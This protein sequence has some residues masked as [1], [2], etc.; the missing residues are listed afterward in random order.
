M[1]DVEAVLAK[2]LPYTMRGI[3]AQRGDACLGICGVHHA[4][5]FEAF[6][7]ITDDMRAYPGAI[8]RAAVRFRSLLNSYERPIFAVANSREMNAPAF[9]RRIGFKHVEG[10]VYQWPTP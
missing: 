10:Q 6:S 4:P 9:L 8:W 7:T 2:R 1:A 5:T 3:A